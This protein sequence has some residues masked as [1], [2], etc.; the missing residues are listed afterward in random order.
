Q[1]VVFPAVDS[2]E[3]FGTGAVEITFIVAAHFVSQAASQHAFIAGHPLHA[4]LRGNTDDFVGNRAF[5]RPHPNRTRSEGA[6]VRIESAA[7]LFLGVFRTAEA[8]VGKRQT[9]NRL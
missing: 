6:L 4:Q 9:G 7:N 8:L 1:T 3:L 2:V 5:A